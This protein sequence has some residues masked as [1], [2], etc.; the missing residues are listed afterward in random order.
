MAT[1]DAVLF[2]AAFENSLY[3]GMG[4]DLFAGKSPEPG[5]SRVGMGGS[6]PRGRIFRSTDFGESWTEITPKNESLSLLHRL[7]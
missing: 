5:L 1:F 6:L 7:E 2:L 4:P 3:V